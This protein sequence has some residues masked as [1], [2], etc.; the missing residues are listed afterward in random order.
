MG[1]TL[2]LARHAKS[3]WHSGALT[4]HERPLNRRGL[5]QAPQLAEA[6]RDARIVPTLILSSDARRTEETALLMEPIFNHPR[7][8]FDH[9]LYLGSLDDIAHVVGAYGTE[10]ETIM[11]L[12]HNPG[13]SHA[14]A[15]LTGKAVELKT[16]HAAVLKTGQDCFQNAIEERDFGLVG[17]YEGRSSAGSSA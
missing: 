15:M 16:A 1:K 6:L 9:R 13:F 14:A 11:V 7:I 17:I 8:Q 4:D 2:I 12:G 10:D 5:R 3:D